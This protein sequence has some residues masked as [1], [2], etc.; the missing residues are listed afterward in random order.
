[1]QVLKTEEIVPS[2]AGVVTKVLKDSKTS[3][4][5]KAHV[6]SS[7]CVAQMHMYLAIK[8]LPERYT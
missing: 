6:V 3:V 7:A 8:V 5:T 1:M 2:T 4:A